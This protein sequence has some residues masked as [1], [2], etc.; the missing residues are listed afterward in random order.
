MILIIENQTGGT[1]T[2]LSGLVSVS[3][4]SNTTVPSQYLYPISRDPELLNDSLQANVQLSDGVQTYTTVQASCY[5]NTI[6]TSIGGAVIGLAGAV[7]PN[8]QITIGGK[9]SNG[10]SQPARMN[11]FSDLATNF[12]NSYKNITGNSNTTV[13]SSAGT[14]HGI[15]VNNNSTG[16]TITIYDN[17]TNS[18]PIIATMQVGTPSGGLLSSAGTPTSAFIG[19]LGLEF[20][21]GLTIVT[22]GST[23][24]NI[25]VLYQ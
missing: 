15:I 6:A 8:Y 2:Y 5:L 1:L 25:T 14:L 7:A 4:N 21:T 3:A 9:D 16:G 12:R 24:N 23:S 20:L 13:K 18:S 22:S 19:P 11:Q 10:N 17:T